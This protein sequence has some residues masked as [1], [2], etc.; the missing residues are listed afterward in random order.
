[1]E[2]KRPNKKSGSFSKSK[3]GSGKS[4]SKGKS[5][6]EK[7]GLKNFSKFIK[8][9]AA[10]FK[11]DK[12]GK[13]DKFERDNKFEKTKRTYSSRGDEKFND[14]RKSERSFDKKERFSGS[15]DRKKPFEKKEGYSSDSK[16]RSYSSDKDDKK[17]YVKR[18]GDSGGFKK[19]EYSDN[20]EPKRSFERKDTG[21][22]KQYFSSDRGD[23]KSYEKR[24]KDSY[25]DKKRSFSKNKSGWAK[26]DRPQEK[27]EDDGTIR[28]N[29]YLSNAGIA[30]RRDAD[31]LIQGG[32]VKVNGVVVDQ[33]GYKVKPGD[34][35][36]Y[37]DSAVKTE[38]KVYVLLNKPKDFLTTTDD[39]QER[40]TVMELVKPACRER[41]Y[42][43]GR[44]DRNTTGLLLFTN[45]GDL[46]T[47][48]MH[49]K[50]LVRKIYHVTLNKPLKAEDFE[51][52][53]NGFE[54]EDGFVKV[55][56]I[57]YVGPGRKELGVEIHSGKNRIVRRIF[58][59]FDYEVYKL[60]RVTYAGLT[61]KDLPRGKYRFLTEKEIAYLKMLK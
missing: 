49:P 58:E 31:V 53:A 32:T 55:D 54:L 47:K 50:Y 27:H 8:K 14:E 24:D 1:M 56:E 29:K 37:A 4:F 2:R 30:S 15:G 40:R 13:D 46:A 19:R 6:S 42:P 25:G 11:K 51:T 59:H 57:A 23:K 43:V 18:G 9:D 39:P 21:E 17:P 26:S 52:I 36:T 60:D 28:L 44:L 3:S 22:K 33:L 35:V 10:P 7:P 34:V 61:K 5:S 16:K 38:R 48:L 20:K 41:I 45:D 12:K